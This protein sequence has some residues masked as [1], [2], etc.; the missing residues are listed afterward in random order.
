MAALRRQCRQ[1]MDS[2]V[3]LVGLA[4]LVGA[5]SVLLLVRAQASKYAGHVGQLQPKK[6]SKAAAEFKIYTR[7]EVAAHCTKEDAWI[8]IRDKRS[9]ELRVG[10]A[11]SIC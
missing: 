8:L 10:A 9:Q 1:Q 11:C 7:E 4:V 5:L 6:R 2:T 3:L